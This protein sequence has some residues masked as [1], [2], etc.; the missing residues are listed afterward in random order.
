MDS[1]TER[2]LPAESLA[3]IPSENETDPRTGSN[4][5][6]DGSTAGGLLQPVESDGGAE[7]KQVWWGKE[8]RAMLSIAILTAINLLNYMDRYS[9]A[10]QS[11]TL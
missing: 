10:G 9:V 6:R 11:A 5:A 7:R 2:I 4:L 3:S 8:R 1:D